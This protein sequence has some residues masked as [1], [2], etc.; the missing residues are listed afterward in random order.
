MQKKVLTNEKKMTNKESI[1]C[2]CACELATLIS[3]L[4]SFPMNVFVVF[5]V[6]ESKASRK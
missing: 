4:T 5:G 2:L 6:C 3:S 1:C